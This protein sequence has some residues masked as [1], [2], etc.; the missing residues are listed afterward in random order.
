MGI[1][2]SAFKHLRMSAPEITRPLNE[3]F[4]QIYQTE[5]E[6]LETQQ[7]LRERKC[8]YITQ[9]SYVVKKQIMAVKKTVKQ[10]QL[11]VE[12]RKVETMEQVSPH[13]CNNGKGF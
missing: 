1:F 12:Q 10:T 13:F 7:K 6:T 4:E 3:I 8:I 5:K 9:T 11:S 2:S